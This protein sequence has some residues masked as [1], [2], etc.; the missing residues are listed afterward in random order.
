MLSSSRAAL[1]LRSQGCQSTSYTASALS[2]GVLPLIRL[3][4]ES[5]SQK[6]LA[7]TGRWGMRARCRAGAQC[8][9]GKVEAAVLIALLVRSVSTKLVSAPSPT[10]LCLNCQRSGSG[11]LCKVLDVHDVL[12]S[13]QISNPT[14]SRMVEEFVTL[15][16]LGTCAPAPSGLAKQLRVRNSQSV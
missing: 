11:S 6:G 7:K 2:C 9:C 8:T 4:P 5:A 10:A 13:S 16:H 15:R 1:R 3:L 12:E 14:D